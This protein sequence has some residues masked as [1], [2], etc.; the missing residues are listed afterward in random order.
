MVMKRHNKMDRFG[1][2][3]YNVFVLRLNILAI[4]KLA[5]VVVLTTAI[6]G[7]V[8]PIGLSLPPDKILEL[9]KGRDQIDYILGIGD[10]ISVKFFYSPELNEQI[11][12]RPDGKI[13]LRFIGEI[14]AAGMT[15]SQLDT[16][17]NRKYSKLMISPN[18]DYILG[19]G[20]QI[21][22]KFFYYN[23]LNDEVSIRPDGKISL[24]LIGE[25]M[26]AG[27]TPI[28][29]ESE[30]LRRYSEVLNLSVGNYTLGVGDKI[31]VKFLYNSELN[32]EV[33][34]RPD[35][36][37]SLQVIGDVQAEGT[38]PADLGEQLTSLYSDFLKIA[39]IVV[40]VQEFSAPELTLMVKKFTAPNLS[41]MLENVATKNIYV[42]GE[43]AKPGAVALNG[44]MR[45]LNALFQA[46][47]ALKT[48][49]LQNVVLIRY[50]GSDKA[51]VYSMDLN[52]VIRGELPDIVLRPFD[53]VFV[54]KTAIARLDL[55]AKQYIFNLLPPNIGFGFNYSLNPSFTVGP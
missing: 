55:Y 54:P 49:K 52:R 34:I 40:I 12:I 43:V 21:A 19:I 42:G 17:L 24:Q 28:K 46:G 11:T 3:F 25:V 44:T 50:T 35:G 1:Y 13:S 36:K 29:L 33:T 16:L 47:G 2:I 53:I 14:S 4:L 45:I 23:K 38:H 48:A 22:V 6:T 51:N 20:D 26:A 30:L 32:D 5:T 10:K 8:T 27:L 9:N 7:C 41:I 31:A 15:P 37:I 39:K 18:R